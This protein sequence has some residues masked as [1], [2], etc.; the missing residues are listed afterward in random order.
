[1]NGRTMMVEL[2]SPQQQA[3]FDAIC[4]LRTAKV[5]L[6][7]FSELQS[8]LERDLDEPPLCSSVHLEP[9]LPIQ[10]ARYIPP[11]AHVFTEQQCDTKLH[12]LT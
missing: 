5:S 12:L 3:A 9:S 1:M 10:K 6:E 8:K 2:T 11:K 7:T 4:A